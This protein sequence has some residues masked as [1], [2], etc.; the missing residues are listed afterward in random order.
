MK[1]C[2]ECNRRHNEQMILANKAVELKEHT[3]KELESRL[4]HLLESDFIGSF[5]TR[6]MRNGEIV[7]VRDIKEADKI[8][9]PEETK[10]DAADDLK[11]YLGKM[12]MDIETGFE[13]KVTAYAEYTTGMKQL[14]VE[15]IDRT[16]RPIEC[17]IDINRIAVG[18]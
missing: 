8:K 12:V 16:G 3:I 9:F 17:W 4:S 11:S 18:E 7:Y 15:S 13:G 10:Y 14:L 6:V 5:D 1:H 2:I